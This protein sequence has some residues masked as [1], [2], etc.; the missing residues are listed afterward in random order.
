MKVKESIESENTATVQSFF[1]LAF[2]ELR[3][4]S[5]HSGVKRNF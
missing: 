5:L 2:D 1:Q 4:S 3:L